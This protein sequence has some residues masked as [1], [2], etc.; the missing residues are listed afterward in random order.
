M[1]GS[2]PD[3]ELGNAVT[4]MD[5]FQSSYSMSSRGFSREKVRAERA[6]MGAHLETE[7]EFRFQS[8]ELAY[9]GLP[10]WVTLTGLQPPKWEHTGG[11]FTKLSLVYI[12]P[13]KIE[14]KIEI[15]DIGIWFGISLSGPR[16]ERT[17]HEKVFLGIDTQ[18]ALSMEQLNA[19][20]VYPL[21]NFLTLATDHPNAVDEFTLIHRSSERPPNRPEKPIHVFGAR[22][23]HD[24]GEASPL[25]SHEMLFTFPDIRERFPKIMDRWLNRVAE[26]LKPV[27]DIFFGTVYKPQSYLDTKFQDVVQSLMLYYEIR[28]GT[29]ADGSQHYTWVHLQEWLGRLADNHSAVMNPLVGN[30]LRGFVDRVTTTYNYVVHRRG[31]MREQAA[32]GEEEYW[33]T[34]KL[35]WLMKSCFLAELEIPEPERVKLFE[36][37]EDYMHI[38]S[39]PP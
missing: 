19:R 3:C 38:R 4:L 9:S 29:R 16:H 7:N 26:E 36:R 35:M 22:V 10:S 28:H 13:H 27:C 33:L 14:A 20:F 18:E 23:Y 11:K 31:D 37:N 6:F 25:H 24:K 5:C 1:L 17:L 8:L 12:P 15:A 32:R 34:Q 2:V 39:L 30:N 21:Q